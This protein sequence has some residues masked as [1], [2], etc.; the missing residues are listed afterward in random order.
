MKI[1]EKLKNKFHK[2]VGWCKD[3]KEILVIIIP[4]G[5]AALAGTTKLIG[6]AIDVHKEHNLQDLKCY[7]RSLGHY[8]ELKR[9]LGNDEWVMIEQRRKNG[10]RLADILSDLKVLK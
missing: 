3:N 7:D 5:A 9:K 1:K 6:K 4:A 8:W 2:A 10:E